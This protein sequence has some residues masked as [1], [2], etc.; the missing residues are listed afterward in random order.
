MMQL[1]AD[2][3]GRRV[4]VP[5]SREIPAR[6][7]ALF[8]AVAA[9]AFGDIRAAIAAT[10]PPD[11]TSYSPEPA[12]TE[13][14]DRVYA[15]YRQLYE[16]LGQTQVDLL[17][18][19]KEDPHVD[20]LIEAAVAANRSLPAHG[21]VTLTWGNASGIDR[22]RGLVAIKASGVDY[23]TMGEDGV[24]VV[25][26]EGRVVAGERRPS[27]DTPTHLAL[28]RAFEE[29]GGI[30][31]THSTWATAWAQAR[32]EI[33]LFGTTHADLSAHPIPL[34]RELTADEVASDYEGATGAVLIDAIGSR[35]AL[36]VPCALVAGHAPFCWGSSPAAA[37][38]VAVT[39]EEVSRMALLTRRLDPDA[40]PLADAVRDKHFERKHGP[41][42]Y[43]GQPT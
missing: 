22:E 5:S 28:Y 41:G 29:I 25:D 18:E 30:V 11:A 15:V 24:V 21:L 38:E 40:S 14:Y 20:A 33:P 7:S 1:I 34:T 13:V 16:T 10:R 17:H 23:E 12:A 19:L 42:A 2:I 43:Y 4:R 32:R 9:G 35:G 36:E 26:L 3:S 31:H 27:T 37:V 39:L 8:G 6:G